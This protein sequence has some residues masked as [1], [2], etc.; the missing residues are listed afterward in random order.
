MHQLEFRVTQMRGVSTA[1]FVVAV[2]SKY[3]INVEN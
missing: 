1:Q 3:D 2:W